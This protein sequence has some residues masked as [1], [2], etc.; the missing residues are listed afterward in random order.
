MRRYRLTL[1]LWIILA[2]V[3]AVCATGSALAVLYIQRPFVFGAQPRTAPVAGV[4]FSTAIVAGALAAVAGL[5][6]GLRL[7]RRIWLIIERAEAA[8]PPAA[9]TPNRPMLDELGVLDAAVGRLTLSLDRFVSDSDILTKLPEGM[10]LL[11]T[12]DSLISF[13]PAAE[14][15]LGA[16][17]ERFRGRPL[18]SD[19][20][21]FPLEAGNGPLARL[22]A[23]ARSDDHAVARCELAATTGTG[24]RLV[25]DLTAQDH[26]RGQSLVL[27]FR[28]ASE[29]RRIREQIKRADQLALLG[30][31][32]AQIAHEVRT[33]LATLRGL[34]ELLHADL[35][36]RDRP[37]QY[38][39]RILQAVERQERLVDRLLSFTHPEPETWQPVLVYELLE[40]LIM[41]WP[42]RRPSLTVQRPVT[43]V[44]GD[45]VLLSQV[46]AN[47]I[48]NAL[49]ASR[50]REVAVRVSMNDGR[51]RVAVTNEGAGIPPEL[52][53][54]IFQPFFTTK[55]GG[56]GLGLAIARQVVEAHH[57][58]LRVESDGRTA[59]S[60]GAELPSLRQ[61]A[62]VAASA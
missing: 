25:L 51:V 19:D 35:A 16:A 21:V 15:L 10:L 23:K 48:Q 31:M 18:L 20:G 57:G 59:T 54:R 26:D 56:T 44:N 43:P 1:H 8:A 42:G 41:A 62:T 12:D 2:L 32:A 22:L 27:L 33:P 36:D 53:E 37:R 9:N 40:D 6:L 39:D 49:E 60:S 14:T 45:P 3:M 34:V 46:F 29:K 50:D 24:R 55:P 47:L 61:P 5:L 58:A 11:G 7:T 30:A 28:D 38:L 17:L 4:L 13:N 52:H